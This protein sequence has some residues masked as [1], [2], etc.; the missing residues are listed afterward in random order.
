MSKLQC[1]YLSAS[2]ASADD[3]AIWTTHRQ[4]PRGGAGSDDWALVNRPGDD[5][6]TETDTW[7]PWSMGLHGIWRAPSKR[8]FVAAGARVYADVGEDE[9]EPTQYPFD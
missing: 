1:E 4:G 2:G 6:S 8:T 9:R 5:D 7:G 3:C